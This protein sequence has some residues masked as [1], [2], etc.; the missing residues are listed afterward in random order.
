VK[1][2]L[3]AVLCLV[4]GLSPRLTAGEAAASPPPP[5]NGIPVPRELQP[6]VSTAV[7]ALMGMRERGDW[8]GGRKLL[9]GVIISS[10]PGPAGTSAV[11]IGGIQ[12]PTFGVG[13]STPGSR[14]LQTNLSRIAE[15]SGGGMT[16]PDVNAMRPA[17]PLPAA[18]NSQFNFSFGTR[19]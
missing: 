13:A 12:V 19:L 10:R 1:T 18:A 14:A 15:D 4:A 7:D 5:D 3:L 2:R 8:I 6:A 17:S 16:V 11:R 9:E